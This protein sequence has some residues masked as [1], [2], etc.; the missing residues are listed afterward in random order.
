MPANRESTVRVTKSVNLPILWR[1]KNSIWINRD[2]RLTGIVN[3]Y[4]IKYKVKITYEHMKTST[5]IAVQSTASYNDSV[6]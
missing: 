3:T 2:I 4:P 1:N 6:K 5:V